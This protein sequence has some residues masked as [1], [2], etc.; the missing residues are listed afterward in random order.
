MKKI[1]FILFAGLVTSQSV[2]AQ[3]NGTIEFWKF[4]DTAGG[5]ALYSINDSGS[6]VGMTQYYDYANSQ[7]IP[8]E[9]GITMMMK[10]NNQN[11]VA[12]RM[13]Y[14]SEGLLQSAYRKN[15]TWKPIGYFPGENPQNLGAFSGT[16]SISN[17]SKYVVGQISSDGITSNPFVFDT[18]TSV[19]KKINNPENVVNARANGVNDS[20][21]AVGYVDRPDLAGGSTFRLPVYFTSDGEAHYILSDIPGRGE[22]IDINNAGQVVG[23]KGTSLFIYDVNTG[24]YQL[25]DAPDGLLYSTFTEISENGIAVGY[26]GDVFN[27]KSI[28]YHPKLGSKPLVLEDILAAKGVQITTF[29]GKLGTAMAISPDGNF[30]TGMDNNGPTLLSAVG[31]ILNLNDKLLPESD[32]VISCPNDI[33]TTVA[34]GTSSAVVNYDLP[35]TCDQSSSA[36]LT[37]IRKEGLDSG[38]EF[39]IGTTTVV[40]HL[41][42]AEG[43]ILY[44]CSFNVTVN[45]VYC[46]LSPVITDVTIPITHVKFGGIDNA[47]PADS[48]TGHEYFLTTTAEVKPTDEYPLSVQAANTYGLPFIAGVYIDWNQNF[49]FSDDGEF[50]SLDTLMSDGSA[51]AEVSTNITVPADAKLGATRMR[52]I[53]QYDLGG[54]VISP[55]DASLFFYGQ[56][57]DY[58]V[59]VSEKLAVSDISKSKIS[60]YPNPVTDVLNINSDKEIRLISVF[61]ISGRKIVEQKSQTKKAIVNIENLSAGTYLV[62]ITDSNNKL[63]TIKII[64]K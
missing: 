60:Y 32:C 7:V 1:Y 61:D 49:D 17:N 18:E 10:I 63:Q 53:M 4:P 25:F 52:V 31:W 3:N 21:I 38:S 58:T 48:T 12:G 23:S 40:H 6:A 34:S 46:V 15:G 27:R 51:P 42:D 57:E 41:V 24:N 29:D 9:A 44:V 55:C 2:L 5:T 35:I 14:G 54:Q 39:P 45:D 26:G 13:P 11:D 37:V 30:I 50:Y 20:G 22:S 59:N 16:Y 19:I 36:G 62:S 33:S 47:S 43:N 56:V 64:K 28:V 8:V